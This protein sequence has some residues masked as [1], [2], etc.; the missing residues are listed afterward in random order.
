MN[1]KTV[2]YASQL[3]LSFE[4]FVDPMKIIRPSAKTLLLAGN[5]FRHNSPYNKPWLKYLSN[6]WQDVCIVPGLLEHSWLG[7]DKE[8]HID[9]AEERLKEEIAEHQNIHYLN[10]NAVTTADGIRVSGLIKWPNYIQ[11]QKADPAY[12]A[13]KDSHRLHTKFWKEEDD[14]WICSEINGIHSPHIMVSYFCP[15]HTLLGS[16]YRQP[17][18]TQ[19]EPSFYSLH[20]PLYKYSQP[21]KAWIFGVPCTNITG[22]CPNASTFLGCNSRGGPGYLPQM[23]MCV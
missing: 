23:V 7:L 15:I 1:K 11:Y 3:F 8:A 13:I 2:Q 18:P 10:R 19:I 22:Y 16:K 9:E 4:K 14:E 5:C 12:A 6:S 20:F 21:L 17:P